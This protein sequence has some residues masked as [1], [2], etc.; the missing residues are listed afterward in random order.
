M[1]VTKKMRVLTLL[2]M[3]FS[4][5]SSLFIG[6]ITVKAE[7]QEIELYNQNDLLITCSYHVEK[8][9]SENVWY[10]KIERASKK[11]DR[12]QRLKL[13]LTDETGQKRTHL[14]MEGMEEDEE[15]F[16]ETAY[17][18][19][20]K[21]TLSVKL[22]KKIK[23]LF[24]TV[25]LDE[26]AEED[27]KTTIKEN[28]LPKEVRC[29]L[30]LEK[31]DAVKESTT[32]QRSNETT[33][34]SF[35]GPTVKASQAA[36][37]GLSLRSGAKGLTQNLPLYTNKN[38]EYTPTDPQKGTYPIHSWKP[39]NSENVL[40][41]QGGVENVAGWDGKT[42]WNTGSPNLTNSYIHY[43]YNQDVADKA[44]LSIRKLAMATDKDD[45]FNV[46]L[47]VRGQTNYEPGLDIVLLLDNSKS[48]N[49]G[50]GYQTTKQISL[51]MV[52]KLVDK[53]VTLRKT[54]KANIRLGGHS[55][56]GYEDE[57]YGN[58]SFT[59]QLT[60]NTET[61]K[62]I[63]GDQGY[64]VYAGG[65]GTFTQRGLVEA[66]ELFKKAEKA[67]T[68]AGKTY[69]R[70]KMLMIFTDGAPNRSW[71]PLQTAYDSEMYFD[72]V[73]VLKSD[74]KSGSYYK[75]GLALGATS[76][77][78]KF[79]QG[80][81]YGGQTI[82]S[83]LTI[84][85]SAAK[86][87]KEDGAEIHTIAVNIKREN[88]E[89]HSEN[90]IVQGMYRMAS[91]KANATGSLSNQNDYF[92]QKGSTSDI[93]TY[94]ENWYQEIAQ[95]ISKAKINDPLGDMVDLVGTPT[96]KRV[97]G[98]NDFPI[99]TVDVKDNRRRLSVENL[100]L[101]KGQEIQIDY[102]V[103]LRT[104]DSNYVP[105]KW[106]QTNGQ[107]TLEPSPERSPD[108]LDFGVPS[109]RK[110]DDRPTL[111]VPVEKKWEDT[112]SGEA[113]FWG[114]RP[115]KVGAVLQKKDGGKWVDEKQIEVTKA[116]NWKALFDP[117]MGGDTLYRIVEKERVKGYAAATYT[118]TTFTEAS[119]GAAS[120]TM[121][122][123]LLTT[124]YTFKKFSHDGQT[125]FK[126]ANK[127]KFKVTRQ[128]EDGLG[129]K[130]VVANLEPADDGT[131]RIEGLPIGSYTVEETHV[132]TGHQRMSAFTIDVTENTSGTAV[133]AKVAGQSGSHTVVNKLQAFALLVSK[134]NHNGAAL[135]GATFS[136][137]GPNGYNKKISTGSSFTF[138]DLI[139]G[140]YVLTEE[141]APKG[142]VGMTE[143]LTITLNTD[144]SVVFGEIENKPMVTG[145]ASLSENKMTVTVKNTPVGTLP[146]TGGGGTTPRY[147]L[148]A[149]CGMVGLSLLGFL[150][151][152]E[153]RRSNS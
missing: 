42:S 49:S 52:K 145:S 114:L 48:L 152:V 98:G 29:K 120:G 136:V 92:F 126:G 79:N 1:K 106:Y 5:C 65:G 86:D 6:G 36:N 14:D 100:N 122:N 118:P 141:N 128:A 121:T 104:D 129:E 94:I 44:S 144:G 32:A 20:A 27:G 146:S 62:T 102:T 137:T 127:P 28:L 90:E 40:N 45:E 8:Q 153:K 130:V 111:E 19:S 57:G 125:A 115:D 41:H 63:Y 142:Y 131:V 33:D 84:A 58:G 17:A 117:V 75:D 18:S 73:R 88:G 46:R 133:I 67:D 112:R 23:E 54:G 51:E 108:V 109:V 89:G 2:M 116:G 16:V 74:D 132:P 77:K 61:W 59:T 50:P 107:T 149:A 143:P 35:V 134:V 119:L 43:G 147:L 3:L 123:K 34:S 96:I 99:P 26:Q 140:T 68:A 56:A 83:H 11:A 103:R 9:A 82:W 25:Q 70:K 53:L 13:K 113:D 81:V 110:K 93:E 124:N 30:T 71:K 4:Y 80:T 60:D 22:P 101:F 7:E 138:T 150:L 69:N 85:N 91:R 55:F 78:T 38:P 97:A 37:D 139:P 24:L 10:V 76:P 135:E 148:I 64:G 72:K 15:W 39:T 47:N 87:I 95:S 66:N 12:Q 31:N 105:G 21:Q 151:V